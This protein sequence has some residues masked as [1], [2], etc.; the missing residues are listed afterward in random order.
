MLLPASF[1]KDTISLALEKSDSYNQQLNLHFVDAAA[2]AKRRAAAGPSNASNDAQHPATD[3]LTPLPTRNVLANM[4]ILG[5]N[6]ADT[7][8]IESGPPPY[9][10][11]DDEASVVT[12]KAD[13]LRSPAASSYNDEAEDWESLAPKASRTTPA[14]AGSSTLPSL[15]FKE[16]LN[17]RISSPPASDR[18]SAGKQADSPAPSSSIPG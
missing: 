12:S 6:E 4:P 17:P 16:V 11:G 15:F 1:P 10:V 7:Q 3:A 14:Q 5:R 13:G 8:S 2:N 18:S 9:A